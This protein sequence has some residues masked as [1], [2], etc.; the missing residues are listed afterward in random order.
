MVNKTIILKDTDLKSAEKLL[1]KMKDKKPN[2]DYPFPINF[3]V[4]KKEIEAWLLADENR[5]F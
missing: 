1:Q 3:C 5:D 2:R 4:A